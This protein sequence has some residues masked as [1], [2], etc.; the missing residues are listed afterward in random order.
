M[1][2]K[3]NYLNKVS[4]ASSWSPKLN[5][6]NNK[7]NECGHVCGNTS[8]CV[9]AI[10]ERTC[11]IASDWMNADT[12][13]QITNRMTSFDNWPY[14]CHKG[15]IIT[16]QRLIEHKWPNNYKTLIWLHLKNLSWS[17]N[18]L[19]RVI[20]VWSLSVSQVYAEERQFVLY[21]RVTEIFLQNMLR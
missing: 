10:Y 3:R 9:T 21:N 13:C 4:Q 15:D 7:L 8:D 5:L 19:D 1:L 12:V 11:I 14:L 20:A 16:S 6:H 18:K 17:I 2:W